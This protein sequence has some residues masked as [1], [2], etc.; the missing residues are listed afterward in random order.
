MAADNSFIDPNDI[1]NMSVTT[2]TRQA[3]SKT[4]PSLADRL[5]LSRRHPV[6][7]RLIRP[8]WASMATCLTS[9]KGGSA[10]TSRADPTTPH[11]SPTALRSATPLSASMAKPQTMLFGRAAVLTAPPKIVG[12][13]ETP[14]IAVGAVDPR[15]RRVVT[16]TR[17]SSRSGA[18]R[19]IFITTHQDRDKNR[20][21]DDDDD[22]SDN[23]SS[24]EEP[25]V[26]QKRVDIDTD[27][28]PLTGAWAALAGEVG[29]SGGIQ[30][31]LGPLPNKFSGLATPE[32]NPMSMQLSHEEVVVGCADGTI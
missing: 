1:E 16:A 8:R 5:R 12:I 6:A 14:D 30:G 9:P 19:R 17:F 23:G 31:L 3:R 24:D 11:L 21:A 15:K 29:A 32:K 2:S 7:F 4:V 22:D 18:D 26:S 27:V 25:T 28:T 10:S 13:V 20:V